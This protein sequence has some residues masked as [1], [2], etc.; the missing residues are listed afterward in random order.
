M[1]SLKSVL[2]I[3]SCC[4]LFVGL[5]ALDFEDCGSLHGEFSSLKLTDCDPST[6]DQCPLKRGKNVT[7]EVTFTTKEEVTKVHVDV[8]GHIVVPIPFILPNP[9]GCVDSGLTC[10]LTNGTQHTYTLSLPIKTMYP[11]VSD[12]YDSNISF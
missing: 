6:M 7:I 2:F 10:P 9:N 1:A 12:I 3:G 4:L 5:S 8:H 11:K